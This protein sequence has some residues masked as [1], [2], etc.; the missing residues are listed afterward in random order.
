MTFSVFIVI[1]GLVVMGALWVA[2]Q[3][4]KRKRR[5]K[6]P[7]K[8]ER[9]KLL[10]GPG[11]SLKKKI[12]LMD[13]NMIHLLMGLMVLPILGG[14]GVLAGMQQAQI[15]GPGL[16]MGLAFWSPWAWSGPVPGIWPRRPSGAAIITWDGLASA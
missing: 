6:L 13:E 3:W 11:E 15:G 1:Y 8:P 4:L 2:V 5:P 16:R 12:E 7:F 9:D 10:R 14:F